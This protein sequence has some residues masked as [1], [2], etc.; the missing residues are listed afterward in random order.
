MP[1][2]SPTTFTCPHCDTPIELTQAMNAQLSAE[3][4][5]EY[6]AQ[7][8]PLRE[9][10][11]AEQADVE[12]TRKTLAEQAASLDQQVQATLQKRA[13]GAPD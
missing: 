12:A 1:A 6:E 7:Y 9:R 5:R 8:A 10:L 2:N 4:R 11:R 13:G 3:L